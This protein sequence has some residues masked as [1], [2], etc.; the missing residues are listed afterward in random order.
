MFDQRKALYEQLEKTRG[1]YVMVYVV[2]DRPGMETQMHPEVIDF[3]VQHLDALPDKGKLTLYLYSRGG[4]TLAAWSIANLIRQFCKEFEVIV[5]AKAHSAATLLC[6]SANTIV[7]TK[8][9]TIGPIDPSVNTPL[10]PGIPGAPPSARVPVSV[11]AIRGFI[12]LARHELCI[13]G[14]AN[15]KDVLVRLTEF[16][17]PLVLGEVFRTQSQIKMLARKLLSHQIKDDGRMDK[18]VSFLCSESG[19]H[20]YTINRK[21][22]RED[23]GL[24]IENPDDDLYSLIKR[25]YDDVSREL[26]LTLAF[27]ANGMLGREQQVSYRLPR[28]LIE[29]LRGGSHVFVSEGVLQRQHVQVAPGVSPQVGI[30]DSRIF[31]GWRHFD[32]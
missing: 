20:D 15:L 14:D 18:I 12:E 3:F 24:N 29:S 17:H 8:Q 30:A 23:L 4:V 16:V 13:V 32:A 19:S 11:E 9:A 28:G 6:L 22:A 7:M 10:N 5:P 1:S 21:E 27:D 31:E 2:G 25:I 26:E